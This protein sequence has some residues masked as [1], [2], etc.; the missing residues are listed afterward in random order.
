MQLCAQAICLEEMLGQPVPEGAL[1]YGLNRRRKVVPFDGQLRELTEG[2][3]VETRRLLAAGN[4]PPAEFEAGK[5]NGC[6]LQEVC[7]PQRPRQAVDRWLIRA[8][9]D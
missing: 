5:C 1:F 3:A 8:V 2:V 6:S 9:D 4:T 7:H